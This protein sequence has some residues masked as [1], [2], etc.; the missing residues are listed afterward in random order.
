LD[1]YLLNYI[2]I[3]PAAWALL[4]LGLLMGRARMNRLRRPP[5][6]LPSPPSSL[7]IIVPAKDEA[8]YI[9]TCVEGLLAQDYPG[10]EVVVIDDRS[11]DGTGEILRQLARER[12]NPPTAAVRVV[13]VDHLPDGWLGKCHALHVGT[14]N[15]DS[16]WLLFVDSDVSLAPEAARAAVALAETREYDAV[17]LITRIQPRTF[18][19]GL[20]IPILGATWATMFTVS[21][22]NADHRRHIAAAN[23]QFFLIRRRAYQMVGGHG[24]VRNEIVEDVE[25]MRRL[26]HE[27][28]KCRFMIGTHLASTRM[29]ATMA[30]LRSGWGRIFA[31][32]GRF[33]RRRIYGGIVFAT[34]S[35]LSVYPALAFGIW[36]FATVSDWRWITAA[37][38]HWVLL[39][40]FLLHLYSATRCSKL[41]ALL[42]FISFPVLIR[43][44]GEG[45]KRCR[46]RKFEWRGTAVT[47]GET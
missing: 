19:E 34:L 14:R 8:G 16:E 36:K 47:I 28:F 6:P 46:D 39:T 38:V 1:F 43:L 37:G 21:L 27:G 33:R 9:R 40:T 31:G 44:L 25:L 18:W 2:L 10:F 23:G 13:H 32:T 30:E 35:S 41:Y 7:S 5:L 29:H 20:M 15:I 26:K 45:L 24:A 4:W 22:T 42:P 3:G 17:S 11:T 12:G